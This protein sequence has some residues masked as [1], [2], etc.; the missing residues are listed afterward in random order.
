MFTPMS[1]ATVAL[2]ETARMAVPIRV[3]KT[4]RCRANISATETITVTT[5]T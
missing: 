3:W 5:S 2:K 1:D 4:I